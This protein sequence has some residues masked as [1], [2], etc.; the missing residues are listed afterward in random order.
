MYTA[1]DYDL[2]GLP[3]SIVEKSRILQPASVQVGD[4]L[5]GL[6]SSGPTQ[7]LSLV[8]KGAGGQ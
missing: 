6:A 8:R 5:L 7:R 3:W 1:G 2:A 4:V